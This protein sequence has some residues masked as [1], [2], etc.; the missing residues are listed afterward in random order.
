[1][2]SLFLQELLK[3]LSVKLLQLL[4]KPFR[5]ASF[6][7]TCCNHVNP[8]SEL[9]FW[10]WRWQLLEQVRLEV[11]LEVSAEPEVEGQRRRACLRATESLRGFGL[12]IMIVVIIALNH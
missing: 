2:Q 8:T 7:L 9:P 12:W 5:E 1:M 10:R 6:N 11:Q 3:P 4:N